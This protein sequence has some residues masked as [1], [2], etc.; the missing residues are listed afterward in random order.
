MNTLIY[1][2]VSTED[3]LEKYGLPAQL[4]ACREFAREHSLSVLEEITDDGISG[5]I[6]ERP[7]LARV[8]ERIASGEVDMVLMLDADRLS[9]DLGHLLRLK[10]E[11]ENRC[12]LEFV[13][14]K[15]ED[16][17]SGRMFFSVR[18]AVAQYEREL[19]RERCMRGRLE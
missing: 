18:G 12:R 16:S 1:A 7:G 13:A 3:Q 19:M 10:L 8:R 17:P 14:A 9:R 4:R 6:L 11:I 2:R 15:F 5:M